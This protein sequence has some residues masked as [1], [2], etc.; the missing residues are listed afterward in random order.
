VE[1]PFWLLEKGRRRTARVLW[2]G[3]REVLAA[4]DEALSSL[5]D[6]FALP[7]GVMLAPKALTLTLFTRMFLS[8]LLVH[9]VGGGRYDRVTTGVGDRFY[10]VAPTAFVVASM[11]MHLSLGQGESVE[12]ELARARQDLR[13]LEFNPDE[14]VADAS[15]QD[16]EHRARASALAQE[17]AELKRAVSAVDADK[18]TLGSRIKEVNT[19][20]TSLLEGHQR[21][22]RELI[23]RLESEDAELRILN[24]RT[25]PFCLWDPREVARTIL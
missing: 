2:T 24:D 19:E 3:D 4:D 16:P 6:S 20:L 5:D 11:T 15:F 14:F 18:R 17:K 21:S 10:G 23:S 25:Y 8:D 9:G 13:R 12:G 7:Q 1:L 22:L